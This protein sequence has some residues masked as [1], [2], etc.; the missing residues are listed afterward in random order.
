MQHDSYLLAWLSTFM[1]CSGLRGPL[2][3]SGVLGSS[4]G[5]VGAAGSPWP[6]LGAPGLSCQV[7]PSFVTTFSSSKAAEVLRKEE[8][9]N[10]ADVVGLVLG[11]SLHAHVTS[12]GQR[13]APLWGGE[14]GREEPGMAPMSSEGPQ[15]RYSL[16]TDK[17]RVCKS[18]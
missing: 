16:P 14:W 18:I 15:N 2:C 1:S 7:S 17:G 10:G 8:C 4:G 6:P 12:R 11:H 3:H 13:Q 9:H 5:C